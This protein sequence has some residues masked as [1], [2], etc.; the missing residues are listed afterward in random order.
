MTAQYGIIK[1]ENNDFNYDNRIEKKRG[2]KRE[3]RINIKVIFQKPL[4]M[5]IIN[6]Q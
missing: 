3:I 1:L 2:F 6:F 4:K 5:C